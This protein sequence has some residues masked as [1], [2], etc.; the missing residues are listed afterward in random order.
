M[1]K[2]YW[3]LA[4][5]ILLCS[6]GGAVWHYVLPNYQLGNSAVPAAEI[7]RINV[8]DAKTESQ[9]VDVY[10]SLPVANIIKVNRNVN[11]GVEMYPSVKG[12]W[13]WM[14][15][16]ILR[17]MPEVSLTPDTKYKVKLSDSILSPN[18]KIKDK[19]FTFNSPAF[20]AKVISSEF[21]E[22]PTNAEKVATASFEF[23]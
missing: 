12:D 13:I 19:Q 18:T 22:N 20:T 7:V 14:S 4:L 2:K 21:Y 8:P 6:V 15:D 17:F 11:D 3:F 9:P 10:F 23:N 5:L 1:K 16:A